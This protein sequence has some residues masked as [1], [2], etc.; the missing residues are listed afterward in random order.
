MSIDVRGWPKGVDNIHADYEIPEGA[1]RRGINVDV[2]DSGRLRRR[3]GSSQVLAITAPHSLWSDG[4]QAYFIQANTLRQF[5]KNGTST[6]LGNFAAGINQGAY[7]KVDSDVYVSCATARGRIRNGVLY[8]WGLDVPTSAPVLSETAGVLPPG[9]YY[10]VVTYLTA[11]G[12]ESGASLQTSITLAVAGGVATTAMPNPVDANVTKKRL[13]LSTP[14]GEVMFMAYEGI[15][16]DQF[17]N[18]SVL[19]SGAKLRTQHL[20]PMPFC[21]VLE[22]F[23]GRIF[24]VDASDPTVVWYTE[25]L[26]YEHVNLGKNYYKFGAPVTVIAAVLDGVYIVANQTWF[27]AT[28]GTPTAV[29]KSV[30]EYRAVAG[31]KA[32]IPNTNNSIWMTERGAVIGKDGG[33]VEILSEKSVA[34]GSMIDAA[35]VVREKDGARQFVVVGSTSQASAL[36]AG[37]YAEAEIVRRSV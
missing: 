30:L 13:Y 1:L 37:S 32:N 36:Q 27:L 9:T 29:R 15:V 8:S 3:K 19:P 7:T 35:S 12:R 24:G 28:A 34:P 11:D 6:S 4:A 10:A 26:D 22:Y 2:L 25:A 16:T 5:L 14:D 17:A 21:T 18:I 33:V 31:T 20:S 23:N